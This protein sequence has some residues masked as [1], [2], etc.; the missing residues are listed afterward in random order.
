MLRK[1]LQRDETLQLMQHPLVQLS[2][3]LVRTNPRV[4]AGEL[5]PFLTQ[6]QQV[7]HSSQY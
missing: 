4:I 6:I 1:V 3:R 7:A 2:V 5:S